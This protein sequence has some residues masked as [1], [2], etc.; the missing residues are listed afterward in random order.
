MADL[1]DYQQR[2]NL[3]A[4]PTPG[5]Q[6][7]PLPSAPTLPDAGAGYKALSG[8]GAELASVAE[9]IAA[10]RQ[11]T[12]ASQA[13][14]Q[15]IGQ[16]AELTEKYV[17]D[18]DFT[19]A[20]DS[21]ARDIAAAK[22][23]ALGTISDP[24]VRAKASL[25]M[26]RDIITASTKVRAAQL[27]RQ[28]DINIAA[29]ETVRQ[30]SIN[31]AV[32]A[33]SDA[34]REAAIG[35]YAGD[36]QR[37]VKAGWIDAATAEKKAQGFRGELEQ[38]DAYALVNRDP[39]RA[40][41]ALADPKVWATLDPMKRQT[42]SV[43]AGQRLDA[44]QQAAAVQAATFH[45]E[46]ATLAMGR[47]VAPDHAIRIF[48]SGIV[49]IE[50]RGD[51][52]AV[53]PAG[54]LGA[55]Q[56]MPATAREVAKG[57]GLD[58][59]TALTDAELRTRLLTDE[60]LNLRL[61]RAYWQQMV[62]RYDGNVALAA[63]AYNAGPGRADGWKAKAEAQFGA[64]FTP[65]QLASVIDI[66]ETQDYLGRLYGRY[67][68]PMN[69]AFSSPAAAL[70]AS[71]AVGAVLTQ[72]AA[73]ETH[74]LTAQAQAAATTDPVVDLV[75]SGLDVDPQRLTDWK[76]VQ[77][78][79]AAR[80]DA[81]AAGRLRDLA[82]AEATQP[83]IRQAWAT[84]PDMLD[85]AVKRMEAEVSAP[86][87]N[88]SIQALNTIKAFKAVQEEQAKKRDSEPVV[89]GGQNGGRYYALELI[90]GRNAALDDNLT[91]A[92][93]NRDAQA[94]TA[95]RIYGGSGSPF[96]V[97]ET[98]AW[99]ERYA[100]ATPQERGRILGAL[101]RGLSADSFAAAL[102]RIVKGENSKGEVPVLTFAAGLYAQAP[103]IA[104]S[105]I[106]GVEAKSA[107]A[108]YLPS[109]TANQAAY[110]TTKSRY[111][112]PG[113]FDIIGRT[114]TDGRFAAISAAIDARYAYLS[115]AASD[116]SGNVNADRLRTA[117]GDVTGGILY[118][119]GAPLIAPVRGMSQNDFDAT[120]WGIKDADLAG[121]RTS[122][123]KAIDAEYL[124]DS[125]KLRSL[126]DG[127]YLVQ[128]NHN[129]TQPQY[130]A[131]ADGRPFVLD[132]RNRVKG[133]VSVNPFRNAMPLP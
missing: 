46:A 54:A 43:L 14:E 106:T 82:F 27:G 38:A 126:S 13:M 40:Q 60:A 10:G 2:V 124:R 113:V 83:L 49:P 84:P 116:A 66:K 45:P 92:L 16:R 85:T 112:P 17:K 21:F 47:V 23:E 71:A 48:D 133:E 89:L 109:G 73:R 7:V 9:K 5:I 33:G 111:F 128:L 103:D 35:R 65:A 120:V 122:G 131:A 96:T 99:Q 110:D 31:E 80:G 114:A 18:P 15:F 41:A 75:R 56:I 87:A 12:L 28:A 62:A 57:L 108:K 94:R 105:I 118:H 68:A 63:A 100:D 8:L 39:A 78:A 72:Q 36:L 44:N 86:G 119:N 59:V 74:L 20:D 6:A 32:A 61:G 64:G 97:E 58:E 104:Q 107:D 51:N 130:A 70:Q 11:E 29:N 79:A 76:A 95:S 91:A 93:R 123:G 50:S 26:E 24:N 1:P 81:T 132:L 34:E 4:G 129:D 30:A 127:R 53:S 102:P 67:G 115:A 25:A 69:V 88:P 121:A 101:A 117:I 19:T 98:Q 52:A 77:A 90:D 3:G 42:L 125:A 37:L 22:M 55:S